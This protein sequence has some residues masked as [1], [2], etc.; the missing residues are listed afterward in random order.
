MAAGIPPA[1]IVPSQAWTSGSELGAAINTR[2]PALRPRRRSAS[3]AERI[4]RPSSWN[5]SDRS[6][7][8]MAGA[9]PK[10]RSAEASSSGTVTKLKQELLPPP[11][12]RDGQGGDPKLPARP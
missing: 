8:M 11:L 10:R 9:S 6:A 2:S 4:E 3:A 12:A 7:V 1:K 5:D